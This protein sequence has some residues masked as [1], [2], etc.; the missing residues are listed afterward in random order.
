MEEVHLAVLLITVVAIVWADHLGFQY[1]RGT[2]QTLPAHLVRGL[3]AAVAIGLLGMIGTGVWMAL[4]RWG[5]LSTQPV[6]WLKLF[7]VGVLVVNALFITRLMQ[8][9]THTPFASLAQRERVIL[10]VSGGASTVGWVSAAV[11]GFFF[12]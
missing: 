7:F 9:A 6:F 2:R 4:D 8:K 3:H 5:Y 11:I 10:F 1:F 12:L